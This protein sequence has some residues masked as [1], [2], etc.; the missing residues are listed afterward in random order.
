MRR[1]HLG[2]AFVALVAAA[3]IPALVGAATKAYTS[4]KLTAT[5]TGTRTILSATVA[6]GDDGTARVAIYTPTGT[7]ITTSAAPGA[8]VGAV[9]ANIAAHSLG[10]ALIPL[11]GD[12]RVAP[13]GAVTP[14]QATACAG[15]PTPTVIWLMELQAAGQTLPVPMYLVPTAGAEAA[16]GP[17]KVVACFT[18]HDLPGTP[19]PCTPVLCAQFLGATL[20]F[21]GVFTPPPA[22]AWVALWTPYTPGTGQPN[23]AG[24]VASPAV[25]APGSL[26][27]VAR[28]RARN[29]TVSGTVTQGGQPVSGAAVRLQ[30]GRTAGRLGAFRTLRTNS[31]GKFAITALARAGTFFRASTTVPGRTSAA[32]CASLG[33]ALPVPCV[34]G[35]ISGFAATSRT[36]RAR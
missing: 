2:N 7:T 30:R 25:T 5:K 19:P 24:T 8:V 14:A 13:T 10:G 18:A 9:Q 28:R 17:A 3:A 20:T 29:V 15:T 4:P 1:R 23:A 16:L 21:F 34:N 12:I 35:T 22:G 26:A 6:R 32:V 33:S 11:A 31:Q 27:V 36:V